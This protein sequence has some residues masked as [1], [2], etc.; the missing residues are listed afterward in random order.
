MLKLKRFILIW[1]LKPLL[2]KKCP[3]NLSLFGKEAEKRNCYYVFLLSN[4]ERNVVVESI[5][6]YGICGKQYDGNSFSKDSLISFESLNSIDIEIVHH[7]KLNR[8]LYKG[9]F[10]FFI[11]GKT[12]IQY[13]ILYVHILSYKCSQFIYNR[14]RLVTIQRLELLKALVDNHIEKDGK[15]IG[16]IDIMTKLY[17]IRWLEHP[18]SDSQEK[19][20]S[21]YLD[22]L[23]DSGELTKDST[24]YYVTR[25][26]ILTLE[27]YEEDERRHRNQIR[28]QIMMVILTGLLAL[29][30]MIQTEIIKVPTILDLTD[31]FC[32]RNK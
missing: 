32:V 12:K 31:Y 27:K 13:L 26:A 28:L 22:S 1:L 20:L 21:L 10:D 2:A 24:D 15:G 29:I 5:D 17:S 8:I 11:Y 3:A 14:K 4:G 16:L 9:L 18:D 23:V 25:K 30:A 7:Y 19:K 6:S